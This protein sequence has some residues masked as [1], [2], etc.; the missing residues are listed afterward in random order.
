MMNGSA[1]SWSN[2]RQATVAASTVEAEYMAAAAAAAVKEGLW[3]RSLAM[4]PGLGNAP[5]KI[6]A[7]NQGAI[8]LLK[9]PV[10][11]MRSKHIDVAYHFAR[12]RVAN[13][14]VRF[15]YLATDK[16]LADMHQACDG[17]KAGDDLRRD[18]S[19]H[20]LDGDT[21]LEQHFDLETFATRQPA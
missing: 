4:E 10:S 19:W 18:W 14:E 17:A 2:K 7:V 13:G 3:V 5:I 6:F 15:S 16:M 8:G 20:G 9:N 12:E 21:R 11:S 1:I